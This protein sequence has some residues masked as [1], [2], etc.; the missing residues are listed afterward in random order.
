M[1]INT[2]IVGGGHA[3][4]TMSKVLQE[5]KVAHIILEKKTVLWQWKEWR[6]DGF[7]MNTP[8][9]FSRMYQQEDGLPDTKMS[10]PQKEMNALWAT[11]AGQE[12]FNIKENC[13]V[14][15]VTRNDDGTF[16]VACSDGNTSY[17]ANN[18][19]NCSG[20]FQIPN[21]PDISKG[22]LVEQMSLTEYKSPSALKAG[23]VL[24]VG[25]GQCGVQ[26]AEELVRAGR[27]VHL[28]TSKVMGAP[29]SHRGED[30]FYWM[31]RTG[32]LKMPPQALPSKEARYEKIPICGNDHPISHHSLFRQGVK[33][34]GRLNAAESGVLTFNND[35][36]SNIAYAMETYA[37]RNVFF[38]D[39]AVKN[40]GDEKF[41]ALTE[42]PEWKVSEELMALK[43][44]TTLDLKA[45]DI[46]TVI[47]AT[48]WRWEAPWLQVPEVRAEFDHLGKPVTCD[49]PGVPGFFHLG[50]SWLRTPNSGNVGGQ[51]D[52]ALWIAGRL[53]Q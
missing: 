9:E 42:E 49:V 15:S 17:L 50:F 14:T 38:E 26:I 4:L 23:A 34:V 37:L 22:I 30:V 18:V 32:M 46:T 1:E 41:G 5:K 45:A 44:A 24:V 19:I 16:V 52:D 33:L 7:M 28:S 3:G 25:G 10:V 35:L 39:F 2:V 8:M 6:W 20:Q 29:R 36:H 13:P 47:W 48:G 11:Y 51:P 27:T 43:P 21:I 31:E 40:G 53:V 12:G